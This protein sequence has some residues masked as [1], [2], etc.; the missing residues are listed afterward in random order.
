MYTCNNTKSYA[1]HTGMGW[2]NG[3]CDADPAPCL[4]GC[5]LCP[6]TNPVGR[7]AVVTHIGCPRQGLYY[8]FPGFTDRPSVHSST[9]GLWRFI[10]AADK[11]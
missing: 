6:Q 3:L 4:R 5:V 9:V 1:R 2:D 10:T 11:V 7:V 8:R